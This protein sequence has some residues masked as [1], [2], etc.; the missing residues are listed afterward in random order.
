MQTYKILFPH[1]P[2]LL[3]MIEIHSHLIPLTLLLQPTFLPLLLILF[4]PPLYQPQPYPHL[5]IYHKV[6][7]PLH[8]REDQIGSE[9]HLNTS[10]II[11]TIQHFHHH[12]ITPLLTHLSITSPTLIS[13]LLTR[14]IH[15]PS[16][17]PKILLPMQNLF[18]L[19]IGPKP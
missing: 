5:P 2:F 7:H 14:P 9:I 18:S 17:L 15:S 1:L 4:L 16:P 13:L 12:L 19:S 6:H 11:T 10:L 8:P 3:S